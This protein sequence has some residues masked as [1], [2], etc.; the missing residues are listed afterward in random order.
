MPKQRE[1]LFLPNPK[2]YVDL[3]PLLAAVMRELMKAG[4][5]G[6]TTLEFLEMGFVN[7]KSAI[8]Q[9][10]QLGAVID[11]EYCRDCGLNGVTHSRIAR[12]VLR[13]WNPE[14]DSMN[15]NYDLEEAA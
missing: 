15:L 8:Y 10:R 9:L 3:P 12:Y 6:V 1:R 13:Y 11:R 7:P 4:A 2:P 14:C 5:Q